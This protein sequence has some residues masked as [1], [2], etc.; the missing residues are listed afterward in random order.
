MIDATLALGAYRDFAA[1]GRVIGARRSP[2]GTVVFVQ[3]LVGS[4]APAVSKPVGRGR[5]GALHIPALEV[6]QIVLDAT[7]RR[8][9]GQYQ[10][11][12]SLFTKFSA[13]RKRPYDHPY[14][15]R[16]AGRPGLFFR[17]PGRYG[18]ADPP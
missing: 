3:G 4:T 15:V 11:R 13:W 2:A 5:G 9:S 18:E 8:R 12:A 7:L 10:D 16:R 17:G 14:L 1:N 6:A